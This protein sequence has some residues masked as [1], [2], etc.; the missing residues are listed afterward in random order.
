MTN[1][2]LLSS[3]IL[4]VL[5][6]LNIAVAQEFETTEKYTLKNERGIDKETEGV[7]LIDLVTADQESNTIATLMITEQ[8]ILESA[9]I[10]VLDDPSLEYI[11]EILKVELVY[12]ACCASSETYYFLVTNAQEYVALPHL[13]N[14][15]CGALLSDTHYVFPNQSHG[16]D[17]MILRAELNYDEAYTIKDIEV[18]QSFMWNDDDFDENDAITANEI[19][20]Y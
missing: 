14:L 10:T 15:Y 1:K 17:G 12:G 18:S 3:T 4:I 20:D 2:K 9:T 11:S 8:E 7:G 5:C 16:Q 19:E 6:A 13:E